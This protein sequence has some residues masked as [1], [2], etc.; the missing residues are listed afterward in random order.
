[1]LQTT[2]RR[3][4]HSHNHFIS[5]STNKLLMWRKPFFCF[6]SD[7]NS[8]LVF[9]RVHCKQGLNFFEVT[10]EASDAH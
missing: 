6:Y 9:A 1:M 10:E 2:L 4:I 3:S 8:W 7:E 5:K